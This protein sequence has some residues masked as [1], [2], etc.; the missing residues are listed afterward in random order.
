MLLPQS[1]AFAAL[2]NRLN[3]VS[4]IGLLHGPRPYVILSGCVVFLR[5]SCHYNNQKFYLR[6]SN[7]DFGRP[8]STTTYERPAGSRLKS[9]EESSIRWGELL[10]KFKNVQERARRA[11]RGSQRPF[12]QES[13]GI[14]GLKQQSSLG[15][16]PTADHPHGTVR[17]E[18]ALLDIPRGGVGAGG[19]GIS[20][21]G[22]GSGSTGGRGGDSHSP[23]DGR[24]TPTSATKSKSG[25]GNLGRLGI[26]G[27]R[28]H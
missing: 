24:S 10:D 3:S 26:G 17:G 23:R 11:Q 1:S 6:M 8:A 4:N 19:L 27:R 25:L 18:K 13:N 15:G 21:A 20:G 7:A 22:S 5:F 2:K 28:K 12:D 9:R 16:A 14:G